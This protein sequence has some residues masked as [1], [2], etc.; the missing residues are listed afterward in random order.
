METYMQ[1]HAK[2][3]VDDF[4]TLYNSLLGLQCSITM[5]NVSHNRDLYPGIHILSLIV[6]RAT[7]L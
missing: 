5:T 2:L 3:F 4:S 6:V 1:M 7:S